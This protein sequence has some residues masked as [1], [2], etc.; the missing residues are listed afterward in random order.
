MGNGHPIAV[1]LHVCGGVGWYEEKFDSCDQSSRY[2]RHLDV[3]GTPFHDN[4]QAQG[5]RF[6]FFRICAYLYVSRQ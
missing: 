5:I 4:P 6:C 2:H 3:F 1:N